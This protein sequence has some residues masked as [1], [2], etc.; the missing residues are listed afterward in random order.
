MTR[1][2]ADAAI[3][4][5]VMAGYDPQDPCS[6][7]V[8]VPDYR[9]S[10]TGEIR[11]VKV[12][13]PDTYY[14]EQIEPEVKDGVE[15]SIEALRDL[16]AEVMSVHIPDLDKAAA[17]ILTILSSEAAACLEKFHRTRPDEIGDDVRARLDVGAT[18]LATHYLKAQRY[19]RVAQQNFADVL[20]KVD[21]LVTPGVSITA[22]G[23][24]EQTVHLDGVDV[25]VVPAVT[26]CTRVLNLAGLPSVSVPVGLSKQG[27]PFGIQIVGRAFDEATALRVADAYERHAYPSQEWPL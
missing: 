4:F 27:L 21:V 17:A 11:G 15:K 8:S 24:E 18:H 5:G 16:G 25:P 6:K 2:V 7:D 10:L 19:R 12:G 9:A 13:V 23:L 26:R 14:F 3:A 20:N 22:P 1:C